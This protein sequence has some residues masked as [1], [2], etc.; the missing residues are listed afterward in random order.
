MTF[1]PAK[2]VSY[3]KYAIFEGK[4]SDAEIEEKATNVQTAQEG[5]YIRLE[6]AD[7][8]NIQDITFK[9]TDKS[10][11]FTLVA[12]T[13]DSS[14]NFKEYAYAYLGYLK[15]GEDKDKEPMVYIGAYADDRYHSDKEEEN[16]DATNSFQYWIRGKNL[17]HAQ[18][19][20]YPTE[21]YNAYK[22][23]IQKDFINA[24]SLDS[25]YIQVLN[26]SELSGVIGNT[27]KAGTSYTLIV[28]AGNEYRSDFYEQTVTTAGEQDPVQR[29][30]YYTDLKEQMQDTDKFT[31]DRWLPVSVDIF[32]EEAEGRTIRGKKS[33]DGEFKPYAVTFRKEDGK[34]VASG[35]FPALA[36]NP[37]ITFDIKDNKLV[38]TENTLEKVY[39]RDTTHLI[40]GMHWKYLY[41][42]KMGSY[43]SEGY[44]YEIYKDKDKNE[45]YDFITAGFVH[46]DIIAF[47]DNNTEEM[48]WT[49]CLGGYQTYA[50]E[51]IFTKTIGDAHGYLILV[52]ESATELLE[53][54]LEK[55]SEE[56]EEEKDP[57]L[58]RHIEQ[59]MVYGSSVNSI[60]ADL[61]KCDIAHDLVEFSV[62][63]RTK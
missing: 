7:A 56:I 62:T 57:D 4:V 49:L 29:I 18:I 14:D 63:N 44:F 42:P 36:S 45:H 10:G 15:G 35:L 1:K 61:K 48:F 19:A 39:V 2:D 38:S 11:I 51:D 17:T 5:S 37:D 59:H 47:T 23:T 32:D 25:Q 50:G 54:L 34:M 16:Y 55:E 53:G 26:E 60:E 20:F 43:S 46:E 13:Y 52:R 33:E 3:I 58:S 30:Y 24:G 28:Y 40:P 22:E 8:E 21:Q 27:L 12:C 6:A 41:R 31:T 9:E